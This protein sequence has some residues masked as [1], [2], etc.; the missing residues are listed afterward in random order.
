MSKLSVYVS[1]C[2]DE[3][4]MRACLESVAWADELIVVDSHSTDATEKI[5]REFTDKVCQHDFQGFGELRNNVV[6]SRNALAARTLTLLDNTALRTEMGRRGRA[7]L[8]Q[9]YSLSR[10][11]DRLEDVCAKVARA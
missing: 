8:E 5:S 11:R 7:L 4:N 1:A 2:N 6:A 9:E 3:S 10:M